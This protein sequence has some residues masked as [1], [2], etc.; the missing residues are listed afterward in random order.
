MQGAHAAQAGQLDEA[1]RGRVGVALLAAEADGGAGA[2]LAVEADDG[3]LDALGHHTHAA[4][5]GVVAEV[6][7]DGHLGAVGGADAAGMA[8]LGVDHGQLALVFDLLGPRRVVGTLD[9]TD[10]AE[11]AS[12]DAHVAA[13]AL[14]RLHY[15][16]GRAA[17]ALGGEE[18]VDLAGHRRGLGVAFDECLGSGGGAADEDALAGG[19]GG[20]ILAVEDLDEAVLVQ[21]D[22][23]HLGD[24]F[25]IDGRHHAGGEHDQVG[26]QHDL[27]TGGHVLD[28]DHGLALAVELHLGR[29]AAQE[30]DPGTPRCQVPVLVA[31]ARRPHLEVADCHL[32]GREERLEADGVLEG[33]HA[34]QAR[35][36]WQALPVAGAGA[37]DHHDFRGRCA[38]QRR[39]A[40]P[41][42]EHLGQLELR[43]DAVVTVAQVV[44]ELLRRRLAA[45]GG[46]DGAGVHRSALGA[47]REVDR[48]HRALLDTSA[49]EGAR[50][51]VHGAHHAAV[52]ELGEY[53]LAGA[54]ARLL[55]ADALAGAAVDAGVGDD[56]G[57][58]ADG[59]LEVARP[60]AH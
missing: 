14:L 12:G 54:V 49:A 48:L 32:H 13:D 41:V 50:V 45:D 22:V 7:G 17:A 38:T 59:D 57:Q 2:L 25:D 60:A 3:F 6:V 53:G 34:A 21:I 1:H 29:R 16:G 43:L 31:G 8:G 11:R 30:L 42:V 47:L 46:E 37:L 10:G 40:L 4:E 35:A 39:L 9:Q 18:V 24:A 15:R 28:L 33:D 20:A 58:A 36:V 26:P 55:G 23:E 27:A 51:E 52:V 5:Q 56:V 44:D 19:L